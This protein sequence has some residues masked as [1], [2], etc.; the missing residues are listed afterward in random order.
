MDTGLLGLLIMDSKTAAIENLV[1][2]EL[3]RRYSVENVFYFENNAE[4]D[5]YV[6]DR[7]L[8]IQVSY[9]FL[10]NPDTK[11]RELGAFVKLKNF[12]SD[13]KCIVITNSEET[14]LEYE[15]IKVKVMPMWKWML[16]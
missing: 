4:I 13:A 2:I 16:E 5:F 12:I 9:S 11:A 8:A 6:P 15:G 14:E 7:E 1:A 3:I 10:D